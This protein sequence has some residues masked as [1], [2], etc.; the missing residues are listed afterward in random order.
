[1][2]LFVTFFAGVIL[3][4]VYFAPAIVAMAHGRS[5]VLAIFLTNLYLGWTGIGWIAALIWS[6]SA[7][8]SSKLGAPAALSASSSK[9]TTGKI[10]KYALI[11][12]CLLAA[13]GVAVFLLA[14]KPQSGA[15]QSSAVKSQ[16]APRVAPGVPMSADQLLGE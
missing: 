5:N 13:L 2:D 11:G 7:P 1:M 9:L 15:S 10:V 3:L 6:V 14:P 16:E 4:S 12:G 8:A